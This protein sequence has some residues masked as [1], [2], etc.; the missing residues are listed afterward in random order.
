MANL[1]IEIA[2]NGTKTLLTAGKYCDKNIEVEVNV[3]GGGGGGADVEPIVLSGD[4]SYAC[5]G[6]IAAAYIDLYGNKVSTN[7]ITAANGM[8][9]NSTVEQ[10]PFALNFKAD[11][12]VNMDSL[13]EESAILEV[14]IINNA[15]P[16]ALE[17]LFY[18]CRYLR[19][20]PEDLGTTWN[21]NRLHTYKYAYLNHIFSHCFSLRKIP[22][23]FLSNLWGVSTTTSSVAYNNMFYYCYALDEINNIPVHQGTLTSNCFG[24]TFNACHRVKNITF[25]TNEDGTAKTA[26]WKSQTIDLSS[27]S[28]GWASSENNI[29]NYNSG[30]TKD[31]LIKSTNYSS[32]AEYTAAME[33]NPN[34]YTTQY[35]LSRYALNSAIATINS[36]PDTS[37]Y[38]ASAGGTNTIKFKGAQ[39]SGR[40]ID[41]VNQ[42]ISNLTAEEIAVATAKGWTVSL[43]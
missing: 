8:F 5:A 7:D 4:C 27:N 30:I 21:W 36:L 33:S 20:L 25:A 38:L 1:K 39:G 32:L 11:T 16:E 24:S 13:F 34:W 6:T 2:D 43:V 14:P 18:R 10:I 22:E 28:I 42:R 35:E 40:E 37:A 3:A 19:Y 15:Y 31:D 17:K 23:Y 29:L 41:G 9:M 26:N 12:I